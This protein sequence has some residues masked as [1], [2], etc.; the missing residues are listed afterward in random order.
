[1]K[2]GDICRVDYSEGGR[3]QTGRQNHMQKEETELSAW[4][5]VKQRARLS[6]LDRICRSKK[7]GRVERL[8]EREE[9][10]RDAQA[11]QIGCSSLLR[12]P[13]TWE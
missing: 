8:Q 3:T 6:H 1:M 7:H 13:Y 5:G 11:R 4:R 9:G 12:P 10:D 2:E